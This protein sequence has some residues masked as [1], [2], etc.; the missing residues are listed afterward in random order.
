MSLSSFG[1]SSI[2]HTPSDYARNQ[3]GLCQPCVSSVVASGCG[4]AGIYELLTRHCLETQF[5]MNKVLGVIQ[6][7]RDS[8]PS[9]EF[10]CHTHDTNKLRGGSLGLLCR[11]AVTHNMTTTTQLNNTTPQHTNDCRISNFCGVSF[12]YQ[13]FLDLVPPLYPVLI[14]RPLASVILTQTFTPPQ[15]KVLP[16]SVTG[17]RRGRSADAAARR[18]CVTIFFLV[19]HAVKSALESVPWSH[20]VSVGQRSVVIRSPHWA[21]FCGYAKSPAIF[22]SSPCGPGGC[23]RH[24][25]IILVV[26]LGLPTTTEIPINYADS[27]AGHISGLVRIATCVP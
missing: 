13:S 16:T 7:V 22:L 19:F 11:M 18:G 10:C 17:G 20:K 4:L 6:D 25:V 21:A 9:V 2:G 12:G 15:H 3:I 1:Y 26:I 5:P 14:F 27:G 8:L 23:V 24:A